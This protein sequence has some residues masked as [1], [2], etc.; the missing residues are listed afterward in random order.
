MA[1]L[2]SLVSRTI[3]RRIAISMSKEHFLHGC[4]I[5][6]EKGKTCNELSF[7]ENLS[8]TQD[9][10][11]HAEAMAIK[12]LKPNLG[13]TKKINLLV[14]KVSSKMKNLSESGPCHHCLMMMLREPRRKGYEIM[15]IFWSGSDGHIHSEK[16]RDYLLRAPHHSSLRRRKMDV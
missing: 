14:L 7:G 13:R 8:Y 9:N 11:M 16:L 15:K 5:F 1:E 12:R 3:K 6:F 4:T 2:D 10:P